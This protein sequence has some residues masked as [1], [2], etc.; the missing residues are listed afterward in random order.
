MASTLRVCLALALC[1]SAWGAVQAGPAASGAA[2]E[3]TKD[4]SVGDGPVADLPGNP[5]DVMGPI[6]LAKDANEVTYPLVPVSRQELEARL[7]ESP[8]RAGALVKARLSA[9][10]AALSADE[11]LPSYY[12]YQGEPVALDLDVERIAVHP[13]EGVDLSAPHARSPQA[14]GIEVS[15]VES[16]GLERLALL[17]LA[18][19]LADCA[20]AQAKIVAA[21]EA[22]GAAYASPVFESPLIEGGWITVGPD[23]LVRFH[24]A[25]GPR[26]GAAL[27][28]LAGGFEVKEQNF[29]GLSN[30][31][32]LG[33]DRKSGFDVLAAA[34]RLARDPRV[35][36]A[37]PELIFTGRGAIEPNDPELDNLWGLINTGQGI[38]GQW[39]TADM[40]MDA[41]EAWE[42]SRGTTSVRVLV[43]DNGVQQDHPDI[44]Q[45]AG[46]DFTTG[47]A[48]GVAGG[49]PGNTCD[50]HGTAV[51]GCISGRWNNSTGVVGVAPGCRVVSA[52]CMVA[53]PT[54]P[55]PGNPCTSNWTA[56]NTW[57]VNA[58]NWAVNNG[59][60]ISNN[61]NAY[62]V[63]STAIDDAYLN[64]YGNGMTHFASSGNSGASSIAYPSS[65][66][67]VNAVGNLDNT[68]ARNASS[69]WGTGL[70]FS[71]PG[72][73]IRTTD[74]T[75]SVG[76][77]GTDYAWVTGTS[78]ASPYAAGVA[79]LVKVTHPAW[80]PINIETAMKSGATDLGAGSYDTTFGWGLVNAYR[81][82]TIFGPGNDVCTDPTVITGTVYTPATIFTYNATS[83]D[84]YE[85]GE[86]CE[87]GN[88][89]VSN[90]VWYSYTPPANGTIDVNTWGS[91]YDTVLSVFDG[92]GAYIGT[93]YIGGGIQIACND[94]HSGTLQSQILGIAVNGGQSY[95]IKVSDYDTAP[96]GGWLDFDL[97][98]HYGAPAND[99]CLSRTPIPGSPGA[100]TM[101]WVYTIAATVAPGTCTELWEYGCGHPDGNSNSVYYS[102]VPTVSGS[103]T[104]DTFGSDYDTVLMVVDGAGFSNPCGEYW[105]GQDGPVCVNPIDFGYYVCND[106]S[107]VSGYYYQSLIASYPVN[108]GWPYVIKVSDYNP[109]SGGG[110]L[111]LNT[112]FVAAA[113]AGDVNGDG[114]VNL[115]DVPFMVDAL[116]DPGACGGCNMA[117]A[118][119]NGDLVADGADL[120]P[121]V[122]AVL[123]M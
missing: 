83:S 101:P 10:N 58:L 75:G 39:G 86:D 41:D 74:R 45:S 35:K 77:D 110:W 4:E 99:S 123:G 44:N 6:D 96:G 105:Q 81:A 14:L 107:Y 32:R 118:D 9:R 90:S 5:H 21:V 94:D 116:V 82:I 70:D 121:F 67:T 56:D 76:Y 48:D 52:R 66:D 34:N 80:N 120:Q 59:I 27:G 65:A 31:Y 1:L 30:A 102:F 60:Q 17:R 42:I 37:E 49:G 115:G 29:G 61:S 47:A 51:A 20:D 19:P 7:A 11:S 103:L 62:G 69:Q 55:S 106:D 24:E 12:F 8:K 108:A 112:N 15:A 25:D 26:A 68:G 72:T 46:R 89:G 98:F 13:A 33:G 119:M 40:D 85:P 22:G 23:V 84:F 57:T 93:T 114:A 50:N 28:E 36:W 109:I 117:L 54:S 64:A 78:F 97:Y 2:G 88:V 18:Q 79:A 113:Q 122:N 38:F 100:N 71:A 16:T 91:D 53:S 92:C 43:I 111:R 95:S 63:S 87:A 104:V 73:S 3:A